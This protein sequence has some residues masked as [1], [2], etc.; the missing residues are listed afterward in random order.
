MRFL[1]RQTQLA[2]LER[3]WAA[4]G[5]AFV[6][7][8]GRR[9]VGK[10]ELI[11]HFMQDKRGLYFVGK[12]A[13]AIVQIREFLRA[14]ARGLE[15]PLLAQADLSTWTAALEAVA[16]R[17]PKEGKFVLALDEFQWMVETSPELPS[18]LQEF[19]DRQWA[20]NGRM[21]LILCGSYLGFM[22]REVLGS[23][24]PLFGRRTAQIRLQPF[25]HCEAAAF[26]PALSVDDRARIYAICGGIPAYLLALNPELSIEQ[27]IARALLDE[28]APLALEPEF[29][30]REELRDLSPYHAVLTA[31]AQGSASPAQLS[32]ATGI[33]VRALHYHLSTLGELGYVGRRY[34]LTGA[35]PSARA[36]RYTLEDPLLRF[37]FRF[38][39][40]NQSLIR[41][42]GPARA[43]SAV[44]K[45][46]LEAYFG[47]C[48][49]RLCREALP[50]IYRKEGVRC[51]FEVGE[52]WDDK[53][54]IDVVGLRH[55]DRTDL[56]ECKWGAVKSLPALLGELD[57]K[58]RRFPNTRRATIARRVFL[59]DAG[60]RARASLEG[61]HLHTLDEL[62]ELPVD[63]SS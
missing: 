50:M 57:S 13:P 46:D 32:G 16:S 37:W 40:P 28:T 48:F 63:P 14:A 18:I 7:V 45:P 56:A 54:Q 38:V 44:V 4:K 26:H 30:L 11:V 55:D 52:Y 25:N 62:Y 23:K 36:V 41:Q 15:E 21:M 19:W 17:L 12:Q 58:V 5:G 3:Q 9:R 59:R 51:A 39:F 61:V 29:L 34:P 35:R 31:L 42:L 53:V 33:D 8:Y 49:E 20:R 24:S 2:A 60:S 10:S 43:F 22:E 1:G 27:N 47:R 6:P